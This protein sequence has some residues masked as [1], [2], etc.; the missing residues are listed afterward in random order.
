MRI[1]NASLSNLT[2]NVWVPTVVTMMDEWTATDNAENY[3][4]VYTNSSPSTEQ[5]RARQ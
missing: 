5:V 1:N 4:P 3:L 2:A